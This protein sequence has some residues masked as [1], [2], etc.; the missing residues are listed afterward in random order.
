MS[1][2]GIIG[3]G[4]NRVDLPIHFLGKKVQLASNWIPRSDGLA[5]KQQV[6]VK[7]DTLFSNI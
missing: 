6:R 4:A 2:F 3:F 1:H 7:P 5:K